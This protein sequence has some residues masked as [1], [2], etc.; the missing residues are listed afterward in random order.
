MADAPSRPTSGLATKPLPDLQ[1]TIKVPGLPQ[2]LNTTRG[3]HWSKTYKEK[4][5]WEQ[6]IGLM[7]KMERNRHKL[8]TPFDRA[9]LHYHISVGDNR[10]HDADNLLSP[11]LKFSND[12]LKGILIT[13][14][15][16]DHIELSFSFDRAKPR[17]F[18]IT[19]TPI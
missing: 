6:L 11:I 18:Q 1:I 16:I 15:S 13:D 17:G 12:A 5:D 3:Q 8:N 14:D 4:R 7:A 2:T 19:V 10:T 9:H